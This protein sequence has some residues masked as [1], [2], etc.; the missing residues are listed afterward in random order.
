MTMM[1]RCKR[2]K[3]GDIEHYSSIKPCNQSGGVLATAPD[4]PCSKGGDSITDCAYKCR[5]KYAGGDELAKCVEA[6]KGDEGGDN[7]PYGN[8]HYVPTAQNCPE[9]YRDAG[10]VGGGGGGGGDRD[11]VANCRQQHRRN[12]DELQRCIDNCR[13]QEGGGGGGSQRKCIC[14]STTKPKDKEEKGG[15]GEGCSGGYKLSESPLKPEGGKVWSHPKYGITPEMGFM[16][17]SQHE[18]HWMHKDGKW[19]YEPDVIDAI[20]AGTL[21]QLEGKSGFVCK[22]GYSQKNVDGETWCCPQEGGGGGKDNAGGEWDWSNRTK[23]L[24]ESLYDKINYLFEYPRGLTDEER[25]AVINYMTT[26]VL[27]GERGAKHATRDRLA[28]MGLLGSGF[29]ESRMADIERGTREQV[30]DVRQ[31]VAVDELNRRFQELMST[32]GMA[33]NLT[34]TLMT[35]E[36][37]KEALNAGRRGESS[38]GLQ[39][40]I[41]LLQTYMGGGNL[42]GAM[43]GLLNQLSMYGKGGNVAG[44]GG[45][46]GTESWIPW[47]LYLLGGNL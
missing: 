13:N 6:C 24:F 14:E 28:R 42:S 19:Y 45:G 10:I 34:G 44:G 4:P 7:C 3:D 17:N 30:A 2:C 16:R 40:L 39:N 18:A 12:P 41:A 8:V 35:S 1:Y 47:L 5:Q 46:G 22:K 11:C 21:D 33:Q 15:D 37:I 36:Q 25:N 20:K 23:G 32:L 43:G 38:Q 26:G 27:K 9:G 29:E 31:G